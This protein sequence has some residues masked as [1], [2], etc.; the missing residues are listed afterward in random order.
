M[1]A[2]GGF[3]TLILS[4]CS[5][6]YQINENVTITMPFSLYPFIHG[7]YGLALVLIECARRIIKIKSSFLC[8][9]LVLLSLVGIHVLVD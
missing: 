4:L 9:F 8:A 2:L 5:Y 1:L 6:S 7:L 3:K